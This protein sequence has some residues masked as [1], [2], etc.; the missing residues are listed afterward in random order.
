MRRIDFEAHFV[1]KDYVR[2]L[3]ENTGYP[4]YSVDAQTGRGRLEY[5]DDVGEPLGDALLNKLCDTGRQRLESMDAAGIAVQVLSLLEMKIRTNTCA[6]LRSCQSRPKTGK[7]STARMPASSA[8]QGN[9]QLGH[10]PARPSRLG[11]IDKVGS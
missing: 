4:R 8:S 10:W 9:C 11:W 1:T 2:A 7:R 5:T 6:F 3:E